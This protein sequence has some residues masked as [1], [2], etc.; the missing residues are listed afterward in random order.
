[1]NSTVADT[2][3][4]LSRPY[5]YEVDLLRAYTAFTVVALHTISRMTFLVSGT[6]SLQFTYLLTHLL[7]YNR[8][9]FIFVTGLVLTYIYA[10]NPAFSVKKFYRGRF[11]VVFIPYVLW[12]VIYT[13]KNERYA[14]AVG[15][16]WPTLHNIVSGNASPQLY[17]I[18][19]SLQIYL[20][21]PLFVG[22]IRKVGRH[23]FITLGISLALQLV[24]IGLDYG[25]L[26]N[27]PLSSWAG[28]QFILNYQDTFIVTYQFFLIL[29]GLTA[30]HFERVK[31]FCLHYGRY[32]VPLM[33]ATITAYTIYYYLAITAFNE[34]L[35]IAT[36]VL[37][38]TVVLYSTVVIA[39]LGWLALLWAKNKRLFRPIKAVSNMS[40]GVFFVHFLFL[41]FI[42]DH[43]GTTWLSNMPAAV[44]IIITL[45]ATFGL[46]VLLCYVLLKIPVLSWTIGKPNKSVKDKTLPTVLSKDIKPLPIT[47]QVM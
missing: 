27:G 46:S 45:I 6:A 16:I 25:L 31:R 22:F 39:F 12:S 29:G 15:Y 26:Q 47:E 34:P 24:S 44:A 11:F 38:P 5:I 9:V 28:A 19:L 42:A 13:L 10:S 35:G 43:F 1:M 23:P 37:Q 2:R 32:T 17:Y 33:V 40:F 36:S 3:V 7:H 18:I 41:D 20:L 4:K 14:S 8:E 30:L 21:F